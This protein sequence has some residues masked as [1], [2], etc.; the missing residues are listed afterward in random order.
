MK[1]PVEIRHEALLEDTALA[2]VGGVA[3]EPLCT[4]EGLEQREDRALVEHVKPRDRLRLA[5]TGAASLKLEDIESLLTEHVLNSDEHAV[6]LGK[7]CSQLIEF[8]FSS[9]KPDPVATLKLVRELSAQARANAKD[10]R[11]NIKLLAHLRRS[12]PPRVQVLN[13]GDAQIAV[14][15]NQVNSVKLGG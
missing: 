3:S 10:M 13:M 11:Q 2:Q 5:A 7:T 6:E 12:A 4:Q 9:E 14:T 1:S 15:E 8:M